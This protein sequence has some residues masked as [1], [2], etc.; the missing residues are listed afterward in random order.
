MQLGPVGVEQAFDQ[1]VNKVGQIGRQARRLAADGAKEFRRWIEEHS[2][3]SDA[4]AE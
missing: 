1:S 3:Y 2:P 4:D